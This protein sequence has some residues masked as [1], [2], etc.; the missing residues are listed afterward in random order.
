M[1]GVLTFTEYQ[2]AHTREATTDGKNDIFEEG[3]DIN[4]GVFARVGVLCP[5]GTHVGTALQQSTRKRQK[6]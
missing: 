4:N 5:A 3:E 1:C 2:K 6:R